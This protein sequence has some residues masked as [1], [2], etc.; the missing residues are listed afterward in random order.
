MILAVIIG[1]AMVYIIKPG[2]AEPF[3]NS[4]NSCNKR[5]QTVLAAATGNVTGSAAVADDGTVTSLLNIGRQLVPKNI[6]DA[7]AKNGYLGVIVFAIAFAVALNLIGE[8]AEPLAVVIEIANE[9]IIRMVSV[10][11]YCVVRLHV[12]CEVVVVVVVLL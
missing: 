10:T 9:A 12:V 2:A 4:D 1:I 5:A 7:M 11:G 3:K 6:V 8:H